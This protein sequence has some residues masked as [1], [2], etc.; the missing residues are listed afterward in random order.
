MT[1]SDFTL[2][3]IES[4]LG[5][6][7]RKDKLFESLEAVEVPPWLKKSLEVAWSVG[8]YGEKA[9]SEF[10]IAP[11][12]LASRDL[13][14]EKFFLFSG[15]KLDA[16]AARGLTGE[17]D[18]VL[19]HSYPT[20]TIS[21]PIMSVVEA[22]RQDFDAGQAQ[23]VAQMVGAQVFNQKHGEAPLPIYGCVT[24]GDAWQF[25]RLE[26]EHVLVDRERY[27]IRNDVGLILGVFKNIV[28]IFEARHKR[29]EL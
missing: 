29:S 26:D 24:T 16:D 22:K 12:L 5:L 23:C 15:Q 19:T 27:F 14:Q 7:L 8:F 6:T 11:V 21:T 2:D 9:R 1:Y 10:F 28:E 4:K 17:C 3:D 13:N 18:F 20:L 25:L